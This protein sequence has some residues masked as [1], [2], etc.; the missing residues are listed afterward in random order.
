MKIKKYYH[1]QYL[2]M[3]PRWQRARAAAAGEDEVHNGGELWLPK[4]AEEKDE[5][6][7]KR[8][9]MT[10]FYN[11]TWR[12]IISLRGLM[13]RKDP[14]VSDFD[15]YEGQ[16]N[17]VTGLGFGYSGLCKFAALECLI[18]GRVGL[19]VDY[20]D[21]PVIV[22]YVAEN[23]IDWAN[24]KSMVRLF[25]GKT[26]DGKE[27]HR[28]LELDESG[29][30][31]QRLVEVADGKET[32][33]EQIIPMIAGKRFDY[34]PFVLMGVDSL[35]YD[36]EIPPLIDLINVNMHHYIMS[37]AY[38]RGCFLS[39]LPSMFI[40]G[41]RDET[42][43]IYI[44]SSVANS[45]P[46]PETKAEILEVRGNFGA[47]KENLYN[48]EMQMASL[49]ARMLEPQKAGVEAEGAIERRMSGDESV[50]ADMAGTLSE[51]LTKALYIYLAWF[52]K[53]DPD[54]SLE[55][56]REFL[57]A[58]MTAQE[59]SAMF[60]SWQGGAISHETLFYN[61]KRAGYVPEAINFEDEQSRIGD[62]PP[63]MT[64]ANATNP[65]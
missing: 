40:Y 38:E 13:F 44:G 24:D 50:L 59:I 7:K 64:A 17:D 61:L 42:R 35:E 19:L 6:Y 14:T 2:A 27:K 20:S 58:R 45:F 47:L 11:A 41:N 31:I 37:S 55:I 22:T 15:K 52:G 36:V 28:V 12:T 34:L 62:N 8:V 18:V 21:R 56:N 54:F 57:P 29:L 60:L 26:K 33:I 65:V 49:G 23:I 39:G 4:L 51:G 30:Y 63:G 53:D 1:D 25:E 43:N 10:P 46:D 9:A 3:Q 32:E 5:E 16:L 48:K